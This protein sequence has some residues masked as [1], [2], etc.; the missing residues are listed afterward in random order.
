MTATITATTTGLAT[1]FDAERR[2]ALVLG[3][4]AVGLGVAPFAGLSGFRMR[5]LTLLLF[6]AGLAQAWNLMA[7]FV[8][9]SS[10]G[11]VA[12][13]G[14]GAYTTAI[15]LTNRHTR[16]PLVPAL[17]L[18]CLVSVILAAVVGPPLLRLKG[19]YFAVATLAIAKSI[20]EL[21]SGWDGLT[22]GGTGLDLP[23][24]RD[25]LGYRK[26][27]LALLAIVVV[28]AVMSKMVSKSTFGLAMLAVRENEAGAAALG[29]DATRTKVTV[30][31]VVAAMCALLGG[32]YAIYNGSLTPE[33]GFDSN[34]ST[35]PIV[36]AIL[37][38][39]G[40]VYGP[41]IG[42]VVYQLIAVAVLLRFPGWQQTILGVLSILAII[43][44]PAGLNE[45]LL[46]RRTLASMLG[47]PRR[48]RAG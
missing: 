48:N 12:W 19:H 34:Y 40:T 29:I 33:T 21:T 24:D 16:W 11:N 14:V 42:T 41:I 9:Y 2:L 46:G 47:T 27:Y 13:F 35:L 31:A 7:G 38:G 3:L 22:G 17:L 36:L 30:F 20:Q 39:A 43:F 28:F 18:G 1:R 32:I 44:V 45:F 37:G 10:F 8:G 6:M 4:A 23:I 15:M 5:T 25:P 26:V